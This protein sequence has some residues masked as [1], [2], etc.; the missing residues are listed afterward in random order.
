[1]EDYILERVKE[2]ERFLKSKDNPRKYPGKNEIVY[3][4]EILDQGHKYSV[5]I[6]VTNK[7]NVSFNMYSGINILK[8]S[9]ITNVS[10][11]CQKVTSIFGALY[12]DKD[13]M[14]VYYHTQDWPVSNR[15]SKEALQ[16]MEKEGLNIW[17]CHY[18]NIDY[19]A[20]GKYLLNETFDISDKTSFKKFDRERIA[21]NV[22]LCRKLINESKIRHEKISDT[23]S[24][25]GDIKIC[26]EVFLDGDKYQMEYVFNEN[27]VFT[28]KGF[29]GRL[30]IP[31]S[32]DYLY[33]ASKYVSK[34]NTSKGVTTLRLGDDKNGFSCTTNTFLLDGDLS[35]D[36]INLMEKSIIDMLS[37]SQY[38]IQRISS[39]K[40]PKKEYG[41]ID[42]EQLR[43]E[44]E[45]SLDCLQIPGIP[46]FK[47]FVEAREK[48]KPDKSISLR[49]A[50]EFIDLSF[51]DS[52]DTAPDPLEEFIDD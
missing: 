37:G 44:I 18:K 8:R 30:S 10:L 40:G 32:E 1:M 4:Y 49:E 19:L 48:E 26:S 25:N 6:L 31:I 22:E 9:Y 33:T 15:I 28:I 27:G 43:N 3:A 50:P 11:Y 42:L 20:Q 36:I 41:E 45:Q 17:A 39:G 35:G 2:L 46:S 24:D 34:K 16:M 51:A 29:C 13:S 5:E 14:S 38:N 21:H 47:E 12:T 23:F 52:V 7:N